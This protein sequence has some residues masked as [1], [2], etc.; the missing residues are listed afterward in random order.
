MQGRARQS[1]RAVGFLGRARL[2]RPFQSPAVGR[3]RPQRAAVFLGR[4]RQSLRAVPSGY[5][6]GAHGVTRPTIHR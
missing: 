5:E 3:V 4:A 2:Q 6:P 1:L